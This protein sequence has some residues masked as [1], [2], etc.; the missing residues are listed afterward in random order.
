[1]SIQ[2][3]SRL[4]SC[5]LV[6]VGF[7]LIVPLL[8]NHSASVY[9]AG[10][11]YAVNS[12][13]DTVDADVGD[14]GHVC[15]DASGHCTLRAAIMQANF[16][17]GLD[18]ITLPS[19]VYTL[20]RP[21]DDD[22]AVVGDLDIADDLTIQGAGSVTTIV[23]GNGATTGD[24]VF[25]ILS[26]AKNVTLSGLTIRNGKKV[27]TF[28]EGGGLDWDGGGQFQLDDVI[29]EG[30]AAYDDGGLAL[31]YSS[32]DAVVDMDHI[33]VRANT[34]TAAVGGLGASLGSGFAHFALR[35]SQIYSNSAYEG[36]GLYFGGDINSP[37]IVALESDD[38][39]SNTASLSAAIEN[40][41]GLNT[42]PLLILNSQLTGNHASIYG[43]GIGNHGHLVISDTT[44]ADNTATI[45]GGGIFNYEGGRMTL[46]QSTL[47]GNAAQTG[48]GLF[49]ELFIHSSIVH[50]ADE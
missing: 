17:T 46:N 4:L 27:A 30:N 40:W 37:G 47:S 10:N 50:Y 20:T 1:M 35:N 32:F 24:R 28:D 49:S 7:T 45:S 11:I 19:G 15:A 6:A 36:G 29:V 41:A 26:S 22:L 18:T 48:G 3:R 13:A 39:Y 33:I 23:D 9:A 44:L 5:I 16:V 21:G 8:L 25:Q 42:Y 43:G 38:I 14:P 31:N 34:A 2:L 12:T